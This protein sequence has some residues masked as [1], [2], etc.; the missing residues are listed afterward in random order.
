MRNI[1]Y[2][3]YGKYIPYILYFPYGKEN[4][5]CQYTA[6]L[7]QFNCMHTKGYTVITRLFYQSPP[8]TDTV[9]LRRNLCLNESQTCR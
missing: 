4:K 2:I 8:L 6:P 1:I 3:I 7:H 9:I 5:L